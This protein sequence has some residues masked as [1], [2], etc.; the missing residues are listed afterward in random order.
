MK[1]FVFYNKKCIEIV[2]KNDPTNIRTNLKQYERKCISCNKPDSSVITHLIG[3]L[4][5]TQNWCV[6]SLPLCVYC[7]IDESE[8]L[9]CLDDFGRINVLKE[10][11]EGVP[12]CICGKRGKYYCGQCQSRVYCGK[13]CQKE[14][15]PR[16]K[17]TCKLLK[18]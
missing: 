15:Y 11:N 7:K 6:V 1:F 17:A 5:E 14:M 9:C 16:H 4:D 3:N 18:F 2:E 13:K 12:K 8:M 10:V